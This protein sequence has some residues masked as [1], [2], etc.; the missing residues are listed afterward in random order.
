MLQVVTN[1][2]MCLVSQIYF[3]KFGSGFVFKYIV[4]KDLPDD[5]IRDVTSAIIWG[6]CLFIHSCHARR[7]SFEINS[8]SKEIRRAEY[9]Y[10]NK[11]PSISALVTSLDE[12]DFFVTNKK[13]FRCEFW[14][15]GINLE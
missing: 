15:T 5:E 12:I 2:S 10:M 3:P 11:H 7:I 9:E 6:G 8:N 1:G 13:S 4:G 14:A